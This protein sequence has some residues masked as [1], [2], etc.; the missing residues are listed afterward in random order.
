MKV[1]KVWGLVVACVLFFLM[2]ACSGSDT[3]GTKNGSGG[4][5]Q[6]TLEFF[7]WFDEEDY[8]KDI[9]KKFEDEN[10]DIKINAN[11]IPTDEYEQKLLVNMSSGEGIDVFATSTPSPMAKYQDKDQLLD[12]NEYVNTD[13]L[14]NISSLIEQYKIDDGLYG[15]PYRSSPWVLYYNKDIFDEA[16]VPYPDD[17]W[18]WEKYREVAKELTFEDEDGEIWG[19]INYEPSTN[20]W[21]LPANTR[22]YNNPNR[23]EDLEGYKE[24]AKF[25]YDLTYVDESQQSYSE[26]IGEAGKDYTGRFL[27][28]RHAMMFTGDWGVQMLNNAMEEGSE[29]INYDIAPLPYF[30]GM[31]PRTTGALATAM[32]SKNTEYPEEAVRFISFLAAEQAGEIMSDHGI[33]PAWQSEATVDAFVG[34]LEQPEHPE[35]F[36]ERTVNSQIPVDDPMFSEG[37]KIVEEEVSLYLLQEKELDETFDTIQQRIKDEVLNE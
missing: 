3:D 37:M 34:N 4:D 7:D 14:S 2:T 30:E 35:V 1:T 5:D 32:V 10:P 9:I 17:T 24:A 19:S 36:F 15:L 25:I 16:E 13:E 12:F 8:M 18:T 6:I 20:W 23:P 22:N 28:G 21:M 33:L 11:F 29:T 26:L 27:Q 31:E